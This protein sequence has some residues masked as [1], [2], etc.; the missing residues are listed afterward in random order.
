MSFDGRFDLRVLSGIGRSGNSGSVLPRRT[1]LGSGRSRVYV[2]DSTESVGGKAS[3]LL[4]LDRYRTAE[5][6]VPRAT[7]PDANFFEI[8]PRPLVNPRMIGTLPLHKLNQLFDAI[9]DFGYPIAIRSSSQVEDSEGSVAAG[10]FKTKFHGSPIVTAESRLR[11]EEK[12]LAVLNSAYTPKAIT[13]WTRRGFTHIPQIPVVI[14]EVVGEPSADGRYFLPV[15]SGIIN[16]SLS[17]TVRVS[18]VLGLGVTAVSEEGL[19]L[20]HRVPKFMP[21]DQ[22]EIP[23][24]GSLNRSEIA[25]IDLH[26]GDLVHLRGRETERL[27]PGDALSVIQNAFPSLQVKLAKIAIEL[28]NRINMYKGTKSALD[29]EWATDWNDTW[30]VQMRPIERRAAQK[31]PLVTEKDVVLDSQDVVG[32]GSREFRQIVYVRSSY[33]D[34]TPETIKALRAEFPDSLL[35]YDTSLFHFFTS[36]TITESIMPFID[37]VVIIDRTSDQHK[38]GTGLQH[39]ALNVAEEGKV[40]I[41]T[42]NADFMPRVAQRARS[43]NIIKPGTFSTDEITVYEYARPLRVAADDEG[44][45][46]VVYTL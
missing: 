11:F 4:A 33:G 29:L 44:K 32:Y 31:K 39:V 28:E 7:V 24:E 43:A 38:N 9:K 6:D 16:T 26:T 45:W 13:Y 5:Y 14:Q 10:I 3:G 17:N 34:T 8:A 40:L 22:V 46:G 20:L 23:A 25:C 37:A 42:G 12:L 2:L 30:L 21:T 1:A 41:Y 35:I 19:G 27:F 15:L 36:K 18:T